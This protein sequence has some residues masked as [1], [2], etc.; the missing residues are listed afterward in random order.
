MSFQ[1]KIKELR[2]RNDITQ[3]KLAEYLNISF[4]AI[5]KWE[6]GTSLPDIGLLKPLSSFFGVSIDYLLDNENSD[7]ENYLKEVMD[8]YSSYTTKGEI[9]EAIALLREGLKRYPKNYKMMSKLASS[10]ITITKSTHEDMMKEHALEAL[11]LCE[12]IISDS[13]DYELCDQ[14]IS[15]KFYCYIDLKEYDKAI[16]VCNKRPS[17]WH[18]RDLLLYSVYKGEEANTYLK[19]MILMFM[20]KLSS[21]VFSLTYKLKGGEKYSI[22]E[23]IEITKKAIDVIELIIDDENYLFYSVRLRR[24]YSFLGMYHAMDGNQDEMYKALNKA[25]ELALYFDRLNQ[26]D[27]YTALLIRDKVFEYNETSKNSSMP[28]FDIFLESLEK[29]VFD[30][31]RKE[32]KFLELLEKG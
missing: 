31:Y 5:S 27:Q 23:K 19:E 26:D 11:K 29:N 18:S 1:V 9:S 8:Q 21:F 6:N 12:M 30:V 16:E 4:Q 13:N 14:A 22:K 20:D 7:E 2:K 17:I 10:L 32:M 25:K 3:E 15:T 28:V 24:F